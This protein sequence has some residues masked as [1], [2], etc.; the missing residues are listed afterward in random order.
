MER[1]L[2]LVKSE[3]PIQVMAV[4]LV[5]G[6]QSLELSIDC[7]CVKLGLKLLQV[8]AEGEVKGL[9]PF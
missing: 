3:P 8:K 5:K 4:G 7:Q 9:Q 6:L 1:P 2:R